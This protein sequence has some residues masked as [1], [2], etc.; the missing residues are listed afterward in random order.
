MIGMQKEPIIQNFLTQMPVKFS[1][2]TEGPML[3]SGV[4]ID[5]D[6]QTG[7]AIDIQRIR[8]VDEHVT[9]DKDAD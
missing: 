9:F 2:E 8:I 1:V 3:L 7:K 6:T 5:I 4:Y